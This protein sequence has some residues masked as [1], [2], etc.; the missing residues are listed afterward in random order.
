MSLPNVT[1]TVQDG[2]LGLITSPPENVYVAIGT[3]SA[4]TADTVTPIST[5]P[6]AQTTFGTGPLVEEIAS[7][8]TVAQGLG[9]GATA[10]AVKVPS[11]YPTALI[12][13]LTIPAGNAGNAWTDATPPALSGTS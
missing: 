9:V 1:V 13:A 4:G 2:G 6:V 8:L 5:I 12:S 7:V 11:T 3:S 10:L